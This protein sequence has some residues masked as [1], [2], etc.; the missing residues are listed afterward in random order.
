M[1]VHSAFYTFV[2]IP[3][4]QAMAQLLRQTLAPLHG[5]IIVAREGINGVL[6]GEPAELSKAESTLN[7]APEFAPYFSAMPF[8]H[9]ECTSKPFGILRIRV[10]PELVQL[11]APEITAHFGP[12]SHQSLSGEEWRNLLNRDD[13]VVLD[14]R[15]H[16]E[17]RL[18]HFI[19]AVNPQVEHF[20]DFTQYVE[21]HAP[22]WKSSGKKIA[23][24]CTG[25]IRCEKTSG[26]M[27]SLGLD[28]AQLDGGILQYFQTTTDAQ[29]DWQ[30]ECFV[31]DNRVALDTHLKET[32]TTEQDVYSEPSEQWRLE[33]AQRLAKLV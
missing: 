1:Q 31:F 6:A 24:Y 23:M 7:T 22:Q 16:F 14:N 29:A 27:Q 26:W 11:G 4:P 33:R 32:S 12:S 3:D 5:T 21:Q 17:Y 15:N 25:G 19:G 8:K 20:R 18:G 28:V 2:S 30:G 13:V 10:K 9:S